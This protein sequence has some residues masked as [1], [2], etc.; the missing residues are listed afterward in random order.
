MHIFKYLPEGAVQI[1][2]IHPR[3]EYFED[4]DGNG[5]EECSNEDRSTDVNALIRNLQHTKIPFYYRRLNVDLAREDKHTWS[6]HCG[7]NKM[8]ILVRK[9]GKRV[10]FEYS[11]KL[12][13]KYAQ[14]EKYNS[15]M[16][17]GRARLQRNK[18]STM[19]DQIDE[20]LDNLGIASQ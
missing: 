2:Y 17:R 4:D 14:G 19:E 20:M 10:V 6:H 12:E 9:V 8:P 15:K 16:P 1:P 3:Y 7:M 13:Q 18:R 5:Y 11:N